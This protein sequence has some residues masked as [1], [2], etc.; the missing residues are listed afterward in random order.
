MRTLKFEDVAKVGDTIRA[1]DFEPMEG[2]TDYFVEGVVLEVHNRVSN[3]FRWGGSYEYTIACSRDSGA[4][5]KWSRVGDKVFVPME[6]TFDWDG[7]ITKIEN[8]VPVYDEWV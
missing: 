2:R 8:A 5:G 6:T 4:Q 3:T 1:Y 7:R